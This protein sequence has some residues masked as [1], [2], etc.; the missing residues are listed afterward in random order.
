MMEEMTVNDQTEAQKL[1]LS[2]VCLQLHQ[3]S[4]IFIMIRGHSLAS[5]ILHTV[6]H[7]SP[8]S[9]S[10]YH[11][12]FLH[13]LSCFVHVFSHHSLLPPSFAHISSFFLSM[14]ETSPSSLLLLKPLHLIILFPSVSFHS[15]FLCSLSIQPWTH[16]FFSKTCCPCLL[17]SA[18]SQFFL[19]D[20]YRLC[21][22]R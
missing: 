3:P 1:S 2:D 16:T 10:F 11:P 18:P 6:L 5:G 12:T 9:S 4:R 17:L 8:S 22:T 15:L 13:F 7:L 14:H 20:F 19:T 21:L